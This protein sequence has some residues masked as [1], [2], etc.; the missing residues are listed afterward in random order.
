MP[1]EEPIRVEGVVKE[2]LPNAMFRVEIQ[3][4]HKV[5]A[6]VCGKMRVNFIR[7][8]PGDTVTVEMSPYDLT[9]GRITHRGLQR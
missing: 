4:G 6:R 3:G 5:L 9:R 2:S 1:K 7:I 8:L